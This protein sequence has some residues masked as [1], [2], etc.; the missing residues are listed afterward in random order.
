MPVVDFFYDVVS[1]Y[2]YLAATQVA[3]L[4]AKAEVH[5]RPFWLAGV[6]QAT[7]N[8]PPFLV[9]AR[10][11]YMQRDLQ[12]LAAFYGVQLVMPATFPFETLTAM[13]C[14][15]TLPAALL[16][17]SSLALFEAVWV[18]G[19]DVADRQVLKDLFGA[20]VL[21]QAAASAGKFALKE[22]SDE[23]VM[24]GAFGAPSFFLGDELYFGCDRLFLLE[25]D[26]AAARGAS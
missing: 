16:P 7:G 10:A 25:H 18:E 21:D 19:R 5:W 3:R 20:E 11:Q 1:P 4:E 9:P 22:N 2:S 12:R 15:L 6:M 24:R 23:A 17:A 8:Q 26:L 14:L 13:R